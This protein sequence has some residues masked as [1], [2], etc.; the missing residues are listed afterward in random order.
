MY[1]VDEF[2]LLTREEIQARMD[3]LLAKISTAGMGSL[4]PDERRFLNN[5]SGRLKASEPRQPSR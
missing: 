1:F 2:D 3:R 4:A 5:A